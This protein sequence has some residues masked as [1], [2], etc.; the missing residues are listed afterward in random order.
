MFYITHAAAGEH[1]LNARTLEEA[2]DLVSAGHI[3]AA[4]KI[5]DQTYDIYHRDKHG[6]EEMQG[7]MVDVQNRDVLIRSPEPMIIPLMWD[8]LSGRRFTGHCSHAAV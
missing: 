4:F 3:P 7:L 6:F 2:I 1:R 8:N 5:A